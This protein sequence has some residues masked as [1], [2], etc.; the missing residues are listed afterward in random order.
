MTQPTTDLMMH[1]QRLITYIPI[2]VNDLIEL[3][4]LILSND[5]T[6]KP[7]ANKQKRK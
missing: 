6:A 7:Q 1:T 2:E 5:R 3:R 4:L